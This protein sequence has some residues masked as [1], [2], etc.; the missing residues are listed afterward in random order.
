[1]RSG[2]SRSQRTKYLLLTE[3]L[4][5]RDQR[6]TDGQANRDFDGVVGYPVCRGKLL[7]HTVSHR[8]QVFS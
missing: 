6:Y 1:M 4:E 5:K 3:L 8:V 2:R 7:P